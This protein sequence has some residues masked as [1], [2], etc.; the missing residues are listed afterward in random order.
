MHH[1]T[2]GGSSETEVKEFTVIPIW[3][4]SPPAAS[5]EAVTTA[6]PVGKQPRAS[7]KALESK[8]MAHISR[9]TLG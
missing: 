3:D 8:V 1:S 2:R 5:L 6:I 4:I 7:R 9:F